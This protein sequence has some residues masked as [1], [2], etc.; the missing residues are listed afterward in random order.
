MV[1]YYLP[2]VTSSISGTDCLILTGIG[3]IPYKVASGKAGGGG[4]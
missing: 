2:E 1:V 3:D 4:G